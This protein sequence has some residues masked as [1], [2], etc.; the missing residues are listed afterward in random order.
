M[1]TI[2]SISKNIY[3]FFRDSVFTWLYDL[4]NVSNI[5]YRFGVLGEVSVMARAFRCIKQLLHVELTISDDIYN[6]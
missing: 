3:S 4:W 1:N 5:V 2:S 6:T